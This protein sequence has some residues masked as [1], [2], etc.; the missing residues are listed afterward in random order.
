MTGVKTQSEKYRG[1]FN[2]SWCC[3]CFPAGQSGSHTRVSVGIG[4]TLWPLPYRMKDSCCLFALH[5]HSRSSVRWVCCAYTTWPYF[6]FSQEVMLS[7][8]EWIRSVRAVHSLSKLLMTC[9]EKAWGG[10]SRDWAVPAARMVKPACSLLSP[11]PK[12]P[13]RKGVSKMGPSTLLIVLMVRILPA[14]C[15][16]SCIPKDRRQLCWKHCLFRKATSW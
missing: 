10:S 16:L 11:L 4:C 5:T 6:M 2:F 13:Q 12:L 14:S 9:W 15:R 8:K 7:W 3:P 1:V